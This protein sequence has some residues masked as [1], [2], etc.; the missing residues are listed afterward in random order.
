MFT[1]CSQTM[2]RR[3]GTGFA[4]SIYSEAGRPATLTPKCPIRFAVDL[5]TVFCTPVATAKLLRGAGG[6]GNALR[7][8]TRCRRGPVDAYVVAPAKCPPFLIPNFI[9]K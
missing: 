8:V 4:P 2:N 3:T 7:G 1:R 5:G 6:G 9:I